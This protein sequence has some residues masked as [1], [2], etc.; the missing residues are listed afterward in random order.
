MYLNDYH[1]LIKEICEEEKIAFQLLSK[2]WIMMLEKENKTRFIAGYKFDLNG[3]GLGEIMDD[4]YA[5]FDILKCKGIPVIEHHIFFPNKSKDNKQCDSIKDL[6]KKYHQDIVIKSNVGSCGKDVYRIKSEEEI[7][8]CLNNLF[9]Q[10]KSIS[11]CPFYEIKMEYRLIFLNNQCLLLYGKKRPVVTGDGKETI[12][13]LLLELNPTFFKK[14]KLSPE[15]NRILLEG[16]Q[17]EYS[18]KFNLSQGAIVIN[19]IEERVQQELVK[20]TNRLIKEINIGFCSI[21]IIETITGE[22]KIM[23]LNSG[24]MMTNYMNLVKDGKKIAKEIYRSAIL[25]LF[26][27]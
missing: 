16:E 26:E 5:M 1:K 20:I 21:D 12:K 8:T 2:D 22:F 27:Q 19:D 6:F 13:E 11:I 17:F 15:Y 9:L 23:E 7:S 25:K 14:K 3:H 24:A 4:K 10:D 18:W